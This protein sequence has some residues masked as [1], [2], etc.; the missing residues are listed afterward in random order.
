MKAAEL[1]SLAAAPGIDLSH[2]GGNASNIHGFARMRRLTPL[3]RKLCDELKIS[4]EVVP[5][6]HGA[7]SRVYRQPIWT[8]ADLGHA[9]QGLERMPTLASRYSFMG[10]TTGYPEL[11]RALMME[12]LRIAAAE[13]WP[14]RVPSRDGSMQYYIAELAELVL[15]VEAHKWLFAADQGMYAKC[16]KMEEEIYATKMAHRYTSLQLRYEGWLHAAESWVQRGLRN[17]PDLAPAPMPIEHTE[18]APVYQ[19]TT[20]TF[21]RVEGTCGVFRIS[22][23]GK[24]MRQVTANPFTS[25]NLVLQAS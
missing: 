19:S 23:P 24:P 13:K 21:L 11:H 18:P 12:A 8:A 14:M 15:D 25:F 17:G 22:E 5:T 16:M 2:V 10:D 3:Q 7:G 4:R 9:M 1:F 6:A 20:V